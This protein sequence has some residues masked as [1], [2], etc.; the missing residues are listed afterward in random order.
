MRAGWRGGYLK[1]QSFPSPAH[2]TG[3]AAGYPVVHSKTCRESACW[4]KK[5]AGRK[6]SLG[7]W[8]RGAKRLALPLLPSPGHPPPHPVSRQCACA[9]CSGRPPSCGPP[10]HPG[11]RGATVARALAGR[12]SG[13]AGRRRCRLRLR[14]KLR[15][16]WRRAGPVGTVLACP[17]SVRLA[18]RF[19]D[20]VWG[21]TGL[22][23]GHGLPESKW[24]KEARGRRRWRGWMTGAPGAGWAV[25]AR[26]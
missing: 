16:R 2:P 12:G 18:A 4:G 26:G 17:I 25:G 15:R 14:L 19:F 21:P 13:G 7:L 20:T 3:P 24:G 9:R 6:E 11:N 8:T 5:D 22:A 1:G 10:F 23:P